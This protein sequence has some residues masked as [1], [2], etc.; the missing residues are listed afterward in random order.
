ME[1]LNRIQRRL[2]RSLSPSILLAVTPTTTMSARRKGRRSRAQSISVGKTPSVP[3][4][5]KAKATHWANPNA[6]GEGKKSPEFVHKQHISMIHKFRRQMRKSLTR[7]E[8]S[9]VKKSG[10]AYHPTFKVTRNGEVEMASFSCP[11]AS[12]P[13]PPSLLLFSVSGSEL[14]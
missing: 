9:R 7:N 5:K 13:L 12:R 3:I 11:F 4:H 8:C 6:R 14:S 2:A 10:L 1:S